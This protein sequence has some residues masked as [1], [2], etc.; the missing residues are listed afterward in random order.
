MT[1]PFNLERFIKAQAPVYSQLRSELSNG[2]K[3][4]HWMWFVFPQL[5][6]LGRSAMATTFAIGSMNEAQAYLEHEVLG[7]RLHECT[8]L[9]TQVQGRSLHDI[10]GSPDDMKF[11][12]SMTLFAR[13]ATNNQRFAEALAK[14]CNGVLDPRTLA[15]LNI[16][17]GSRRLTF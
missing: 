13:V 4:S 17:S 15:L 9:V 12:S 10:F 1:D 14:Y 3:T 11:Q 2:K 5:A 7:P 6:G 8:E 16:T